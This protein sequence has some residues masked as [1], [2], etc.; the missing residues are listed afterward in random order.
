MQ[1]E[2][3]KLEENNAELLNQLE[4]VIQMYQYLKE[5]FNE[6]VESQQK[7]VKLCEEVAQKSFLLKSECSK[8]EQ[9]K[10]ILELKIKK[11]EN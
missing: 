2:N 3:Y 1:K 8:L 4:E 10:K 11:Q 7:D 9:E 6:E 5:K